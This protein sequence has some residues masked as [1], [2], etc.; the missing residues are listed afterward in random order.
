M[1]VSYLLSLGSTFFVR[2]TSVPNHW[3]IS[4]GPELDFLK[5]ASCKQNYQ[6]F[7]LVEIIKHQHLF[8]ATTCYALSRPSTNPE[9]GF[10]PSECWKYTRAPFFFF[11]FLFLFLFCKSLIISDKEIQGYMPK[12]KHQFFYLPMLVSHLESSDL[13]YWVDCLQHPLAS[14]LIP[15]RTSLIP[16][17]TLPCPF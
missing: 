13:V 2:A 16:L 6:E 17:L 12:S 7:F 8:C 11:S 10:Q 14:S 1:I 3:K 5:Q 9:F 4:L 15:L